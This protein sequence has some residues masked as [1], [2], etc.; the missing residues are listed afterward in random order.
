VHASHGLTSILV[1]HNQ[2]LAGRCDR[3][4]RLEAGHMKADLA[5]TGKPTSDGLS[6]LPET[7]ISDNGAC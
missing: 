1:T 6:E 5:K 4:M 7:R 3:V 2:E